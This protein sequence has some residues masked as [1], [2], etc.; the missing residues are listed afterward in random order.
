MKKI[1]VLT[2]AVGIAATAVTLFISSCN[3]NSNATTPAPTVATVTTSSVTAITYSTAI[4]GG[5]VT[6]DAS[7]AA[8]TAAGVCYSSTNK[9]P[10]LTNASWVTNNAASPGAFTSNLI[11][12]APGTVYYV[13]AYATND[14]GT[15]YGSVVTFTTSGIDVD[16]YTG[17]TAIGNFSLTTGNPNLVQSFTADKSANLYAIN[18]YIQTGYNSMGTINLNLELKN[19]APLGTTFGTVLASSE[20]I[21]VN[22]TASAG[23]LSNQLV[24]FT[25]NTPVAI[26]SGSVYSFA[27][28]IPSAETVGAYYTSGSF[29][30]GTLYNNTGTGGAYTTIPGYLMFQTVAF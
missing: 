11:Q 16:E 17:K 15:A 5:I 2:L 27:V 24:T 25:F 22:A 28:I 6:A 26:I 29:A 10:S 19:G 8:I 3:K 18:V 30:G 4:A 7:G 13:C 23:L 12:L 9:I 14:V 21:A 20:T 1:T